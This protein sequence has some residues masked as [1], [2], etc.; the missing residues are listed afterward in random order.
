MIVVVDHIKTDK[1]S[2]VLIYRRKFPKDLIP[3]VPSGG[4]G[5]RGRT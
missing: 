3:F 4:S 1:T 5:G 2:G